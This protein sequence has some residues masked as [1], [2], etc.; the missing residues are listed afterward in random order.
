MIKIAF[1]V[2]GQTEQ[3][4]INKL[5]SE[6]L[7]GEGITTIQKKIT[8]GTNVPKHEFIRSHTI[9]RKSKYTILINDCG[10][11]NKVKSEIL[12]NISSLRENG[13]NCIIGLRDLYPL[14]ID[15]LPLLEKGLKYL[16]YSLRSL[17]SPF[18]IVIAVQEVETWF[19]AE[20]SHFK[21]IDRQLN[22]A[23]IKAKLGF[24]PFTIDPLSRKHPSED[25]NNIYKLVGKSY[26]KKYWQVRSIINKLNF[27]NITNNLRYEIDSLNKLISAIE[28]AKNIP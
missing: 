21:R 7:R 6:I 23:F 15:E 26:N 12:D 13:Y 9:S 17:K 24:N 3:I 11:D 14:P 20:T 10:S 25:L 19:L 8:G 22:P 4:F 2:E 1:F 18:D 5:V 28:S 27:Q 16:P